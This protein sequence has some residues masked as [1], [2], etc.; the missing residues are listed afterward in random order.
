M[1]KLV[2]I[3]DEQVI[4]KGLVHTIE[5]AEINCSIVRECRNGIE[6]IE[7]IK[8]TKPDI[9]IVDINMPVMDGLEMIKQ[10]Y[11]DFDYT[12]I[13]LSGYTDFQYAQHAMQYGV[14]GYLLKPL[15]KDEFIET[16]LRAQKQCEVRRVFTQ[17]LRLKEEY[18]EIDLFRDNYY[19]STNDKIAKQ[20]IDYIHSNYQ[21]KI[22]IRD[23]VEELN[24]SETYINK[25][26]KAAVGTTIIEYLNRYRTQKGLDLIKEGNIPIQEVSWRCGIGEYKYFNTVFKKY[27]GCS[28][29]EYINKI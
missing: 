19:K 24:Y 9:I 21:N 5:M 4:R 6:G 23:I 12:A 22:L 3:E 14:M 28:P 10:T 16:I 11:E 13:I 18:R 7:A 27:I 15:D 2:I 17:N 26:F 25:R 29:K 1:Y 8:E 20:I